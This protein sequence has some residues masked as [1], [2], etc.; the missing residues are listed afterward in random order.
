MSL[1]S[2]ST[3]ELKN[4]IELILGELSNLMI[5]SEEEKNSTQETL[6]EIIENNE[7]NLTKMMDNLAK[8][9]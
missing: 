4:N 8:I 6:F 1:I 7:V 3:T 9:T 5:I 2:K